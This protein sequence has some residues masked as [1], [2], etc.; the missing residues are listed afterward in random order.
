MRGEGRF[1]TDREHAETSMGGF[2]LFDDQGWNRTFWP[3]NPGGKRVRPDRSVRVLG[4]FRDK[5]KRKPV[6][7]I[8]NASFADFTPEH[9]AVPVVQPES[10][11]PGL[12]SHF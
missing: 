9:H 12:N 10:P 8:E 7:F 6:A 2:W 11:L 4:N 5:V 3:P 1:P